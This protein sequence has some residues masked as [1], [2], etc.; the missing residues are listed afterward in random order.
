MRILLFLQKKILQL[1]KEAER[2]NFDDISRDGPKV[3]K[4]IT[5]V[6]VDTLSNDEKTR[7]SVKTFAESMS[8]FVDNAEAAADATIISSKALLEPLESARDDLEKNPAVKAKIDS[9]KSEIVDLI[10]ALETPAS[11][12]NGNPIEPMTSAFSEKSTFS[13]VFAPVSAVF[14]VLLLG[15]AAH[16]CKSAMNNKYESI[17][18]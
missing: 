8:A 14:S 5:S 2:G 16:K 18:V 4:E 11:A 1:A 6:L 13:P 12:K 10:V 3:F 9:L 7:Q 15:L 17:D